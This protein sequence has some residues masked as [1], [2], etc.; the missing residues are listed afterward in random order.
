MDFLEKDLENI[1]FNAS[2]EQLNKRGLQV[3]GKRFR[4]LRIGNYGIADMVTAE[5][6]STYHGDKYYKI[7]IY[8]LK[9]DKIEIGAYLQALN[10]AVGLISYLEK[11][12][13]ISILVNIVLI[14][15]TVNKVSNAVYLPRLFTNTSFDIE[16]Y[17]GIGSV[18]I[19]E[20]TYELDGLKFNSLNRDYALVNEG[21]NF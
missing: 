1:V 20:Y 11:R 3:K 9:K 21:F 19:Y 12:T 18:D 8:E 5:L 16:T 2:D 6:R 10:Y 13:S 17:T 14:G 15:K 4:Q 7:T